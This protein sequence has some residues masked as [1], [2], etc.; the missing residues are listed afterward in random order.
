MISNDGWPRVPLGEREEG[1]GRG[2]AWSPCPYNEVRMQVGLRAGCPRM[3]R[4]AGE[5]YLGSRR[6][7][8][9]GGAYKLEGSKVAV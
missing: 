1:G 4:V 9:L 7:Y 3:L 2:L 6:Y 5:G 8:M